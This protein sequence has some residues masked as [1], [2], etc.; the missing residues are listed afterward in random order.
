MAKDEGVITS[1][2]PEWLNTIV[3]PEYEDAGLYEIIL[4]FVIHSPCSGHSSK[5]ISFTE[6]GWK[7]KPWY[8]PRYLKEKL[9]EVIFGTDKRILKM[10]DSKAK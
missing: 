8:S 7:P 2:A 5:G 1:T 6:R 3:P 10:V 9:D 4:F